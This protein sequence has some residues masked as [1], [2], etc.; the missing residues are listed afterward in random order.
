MNTTKKG[1]LFEKKVFAIIKELIAQD[2][3]FTPSDRSFVYEKHKYFSTDRG[4][5]II[6]DLV[7]ESFRE[8]G[9]IPNLIVLIEC[10]DKN[11]AISVS[12]LESFYAKKQQVARANCK[13]LLFI[14]SELQ[15][16]ALTFAMSIGMGVIRILDEDTLNW[17]VE[18]TNQNLKTS[19]GNTLA[20][21]VIN[22]LC[23]PIVFANYNNIFALINDKPFI[24]VEDAMIELSNT[25]ASGADIQNGFE[26]NV[27]PPHNFIE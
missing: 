16:S 14:T 11:R 17:F 18:R 12:D 1:D 3:F 5:E 15:E 10:K 19:P 27:L 6:F 21:N 24:S 20:F 4:K 22:A 23:S 9:L 8:D 13:C 25:S 26:K 7:I 2:K